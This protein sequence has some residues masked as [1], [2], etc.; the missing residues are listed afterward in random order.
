MNELLAHL[1]GDYIF[2]S[3]W[4]AVKKTSDW[5]AALLHGILYSL[6]FIFLTQNP[7]VLSVICLSHAVIDRFRLAN[8]VA[9]I[10]NWNFSATGYDESRPVWL[11]TW[12]MIIT[13]NT[14]HLLIN[15]LALKL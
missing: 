2:Q 3:D 7:L 14:I 15:H 9:R 6:P 12:L 4:M 1:V 13:D 8:W 10:K 5:E 11:T